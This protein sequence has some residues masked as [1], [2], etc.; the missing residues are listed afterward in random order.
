MRSLFKTSMSVSQLACETRRMRQRSTRCRGGGIT[1]SCSR[2]E[3]VCEG[4]IA[5]APL[6]EA[7]AVA[8][9][10]T[11][12]SFLRRVTEGS[13]EV[14]LL[15]QGDMWEVSLRRELVERLMAWEEAAAAV[16]ARNYVLAFVRIVQR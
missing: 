5:T 6:E 13:T 8:E 12:A 7:A 1:S 14:V 4:S 9:I 3:R 15:W 16:G 10:S 2:S 11:L